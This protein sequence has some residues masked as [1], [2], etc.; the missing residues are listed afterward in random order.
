MLLNRV[1]RKT[2]WRRQ[3]SRH[4]KDEREW[5]RC[6]SGR[7][8]SQAEGT[9]CAYSP[10]AGICLACSRNSKEASVTGAASHTSCCLGLCS[11]LQ[12]L[13]PQM[14]PNCLDGSGHSP[15]PL[16]GLP[17]S[18]THQLGPS[19]RAWT[20]QVHLSVLHV[21][22]ALL[23]LMRGGCSAAAGV[24]ALESDFLPLTS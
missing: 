24:L 7:R 19:R 21:P 10:E 16:P 8:A 2:S 17:S 3:L 4:G 1:V 23:V 22:H 13:Q 12:I 5:A 20:A 18:H 11:L 14:M 6:I 9:A 15:S